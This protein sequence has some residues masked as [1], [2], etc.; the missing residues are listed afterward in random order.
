MVG[1]KKSVKK[2]PPVVLSYLFLKRETKIIKEFTALLFYLL[3]H[4]PFGAT[5]FI[6]GVDVLFPIILQINLIK[7]K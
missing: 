3:F 1:N 7:S 6:N 4:I 5:K 2:L